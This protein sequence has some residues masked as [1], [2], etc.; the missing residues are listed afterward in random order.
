MSLVRLHK[1]RFLDNQFMHTK[2]TYIQYVIVQCT[3]C[4]RPKPYLKRSQKYLDT[5][6]SNGDVV[7]Q[8]KNTRI[9]KF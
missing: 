7:E 9:T 2:T 1:A 6:R 8:G 3:V 4:T 5:H